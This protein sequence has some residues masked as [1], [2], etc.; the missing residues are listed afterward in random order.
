M[1]VSWFGCLLKQK[2]LV[3]FGLMLFPNSF[4]FEIKINC[5]LKRKLL[6]ATKLE[7]N[8]YLNILCN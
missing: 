1:D 4:G 7:L 2:R 5:G 8:I 3:P 6:F